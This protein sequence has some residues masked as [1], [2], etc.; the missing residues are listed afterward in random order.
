M[1]AF[2]RDREKKF[3]VWKVRSRLFKKQFLQVFIG[4]ADLGNPKNDEIRLKLHLP[5]S[6]ALFIRSNQNKTPPA[7]SKD[8]LWDSLSP[9]QNFVSHYL[10]Y[11]I[12]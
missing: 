10:S 9:Y 4:K 1:K 5:L 11:L 12:M 3:F 6:F 8:P 2:P 7:S